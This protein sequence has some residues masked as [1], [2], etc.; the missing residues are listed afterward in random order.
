M[1]TK[2]TIHRELNWFLYEVVFPEVTRE[3]EQEFQRTVAELE[4][5][6]ALQ[7][8]P[9]HDLFLELDAAIGAFMRDVY[10]AVFQAGWECG[11]DPNRLIFWPEKS[12]PTA[13]DPELTSLS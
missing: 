11:R 3:I 12:K 9:G 2:P 10:M 1:D 13:G 5:F 7:T 8:G 4:A 6:P